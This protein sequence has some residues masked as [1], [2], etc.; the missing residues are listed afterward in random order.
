MSTFVV[1]PESTNKQGKNYTAPP[2]GEATQTGKIAEK[3]GTGKHAK[4]AIIWFSITWSFYFASGISLLI[5]MKNFFIE[6]TN[7]IDDIGTVWGIF[8][9]IITLAMGYLFGKSKE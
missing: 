3:I 1:P 6:S 7:I 9:P 4:N 2:K 8:V 5:F